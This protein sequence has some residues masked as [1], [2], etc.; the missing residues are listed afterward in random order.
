MK[1]ALSKLLKGWTGLIAEMHSSTKYQSHPRSV[2]WIKYQVPEPSTVGD[3]VLDGLAVP[4][5]P[6][7]S[8]GLRPLSAS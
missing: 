3:A 1:R 6:T 8:I 7:A 5:L 4:K 2:M